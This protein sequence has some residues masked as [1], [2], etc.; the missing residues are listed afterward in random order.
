MNIYR[1][2]RNRCQAQWTGARSGWCGHLRAES[3]LQICTNSKTSCEIWMDG[4]I[5][6]QISEWRIYCQIIHFAL[7]HTGTVIHVILPIS[8]WANPNPFTYD[9]VLVIKTIFT[10]LLT[11]LSWKIPKIITRVVY[12]TSQSFFGFIYSWP[13]PDL[14]VNQHPSGKIETQ[15]KTSCPR[16]KAKE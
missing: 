9:I 4:P 16:Q 1:D 8:R 7:S 5:V 15:Q 11:V 13:A 12:K 3:I 14:A 10:S 2:L 6:E